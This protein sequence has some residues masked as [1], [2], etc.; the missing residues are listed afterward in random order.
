M[1]LK[2]PPSPS[3]NYTTPSVIFPF[4]WHPLLSPQMPKDL[5]KPRSSSVSPLAPKLDMSPLDGMATQISATTSVTLKKELPAPPSSQCPKLL[6]F[7][8]LAQIVTPHLD[9]SQYNLELGPRK[10]WQEVVKE[11]REEQLSGASTRRAEGIAR[12]RRLDLRRQEGG[13]RRGRLTKRRGPSTIFVTVP[14]ERA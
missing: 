8:K 1:V 13:G 7:S 10:T 5:S 4:S 6:G 3:K 11:W 9:L 14:R 12:R 2:V